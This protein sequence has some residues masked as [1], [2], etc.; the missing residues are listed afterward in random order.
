LV[1]L[2]LASNSKDPTVQGNK[3]VFH[4]W[5]AATQAPQQTDSIVPLLFLIPVPFVL[6]SYLHIQ[7]LW[8]YKQMC[9]G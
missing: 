3:D 9:T 4:L 5:L 8:I 7:V 2:K 1:K 6:F